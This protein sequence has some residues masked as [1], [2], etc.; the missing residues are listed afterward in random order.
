VVFY[1]YYGD[2]EMIR[3][4][5]SD[6]SLRLWIKVN[7]MPLLLGMIF[8]IGILLG[9]MI[10]TQISAAGIKALEIAAKNFMIKREEQE[11]SKSFISALLPNIAAWTAVFLSGFC[12]VSAPVTILIPLI[13]GMGFGM[14]AASI[15]I[16]ISNSGLSYICIHLLPNIVIS[17]IILSISCNDSLKMSKFFWNT[18]NLSPKLQNISSITVPVFCGKMILYGLIILFGA[19]MEAYSYKIL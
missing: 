18:M 14:L 15:F 12:A 8:L 4:K 10:S 1:S 3:E 7:S 19:M 9:A 6:M 11:I 5:N 17:S 13:R 2:E 16:N